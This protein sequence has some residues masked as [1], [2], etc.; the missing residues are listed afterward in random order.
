MKLKLVNYVGDIKE[1]KISPK[2][3]L[4]FQFAIYEVISGDEVLTIY[5]KDVTE[6]YFNTELRF[7]SYHDEKI[8]IYSVEQLK[9]INKLNLEA[10]SYERA[11]ALDKF[12]D[13]TRKKQNIKVKE[14]R[15]EK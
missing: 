7:I 9:L 10:S 13:E 12:V 11:D 4:N 1:F 8:S 2:K 6:D 15:N 5:Y 14:K 3:L